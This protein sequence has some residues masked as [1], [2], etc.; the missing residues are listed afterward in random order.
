MNIR[1]RYRIYII[2]KNIRKEGICKEYWNG[3]EISLLPEIRKPKDS[4]FWRIDLDPVKISVDPRPG[5]MKI[6]HVL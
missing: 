3:N 4:V 5:R 6:K 1:Q 2:C